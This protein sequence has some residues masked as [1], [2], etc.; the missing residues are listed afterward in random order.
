MDPDEIDVHEAT[1]RSESGGG[2]ANKATDPSSHPP[3]TKPVSEE[4]DRQNSANRGAADRNAADID[5]TS[6]REKSNL[7]GDSSRSSGADEATTDRGGPAS[8]ALPGIAEDKTV[9]SAPTSSSVPLQPTH[10]GT[11]AEITRVLLGHQLDHFYLETLIGGGGMGAVFRA[12][13]TR[14]DRTVAIKV[15]PRVGEDA[16]LQRRF[17][18]EAQS[19]ARLDHPNIARVYD[20][21]QHGGWH[22]IVFE[23]IEGIN[24]RDLVQRDGVLSVDDAVFYIRQIAEALDHAFRRGVVHRDIKPSNVLIT[25]GGQ[26]K[27][28]DMGLA[29]AQQLEMTDD[30]TAS[31]VTLG[32]F[33]YISPEQARD[34]RDTDV[35]SDIYSL[36]CTLYFA[37]TGR[38][39]YPSGTVLQ[40]LLS[41]GSSPPPDPRR[42]RRDLSASLVAVLHKML[43]KQ[44]ADRYRRPLDLISD[45]YQLA[46]RDHLV[47]ALSAGSIALAAPSRFVRTMEYHLPW[48]AAVLVLLVSAGWMQILSS[49]GRDL[50]LTAVPPRVVAETGPVENP[51]VQGGTDMASPPSLPTIAAP[52]PTNQSPSSGSS[53]E[54]GTGGNGPTGTG[55]NGDSIPQP[56]NRDATGDS[57]VGSDSSSAAPNASGNGAPIESSVGEDAAARPPQFPGV[58]NLAVLEGG[59]QRSGTAGATGP[60]NMAE[61]TQRSVTVVRVVGNDADAGGIDRGGRLLVTSLREAFEAARSNTGIAVIEIFDGTVRTGPLTLPRPGLI[62]RGVS[63]V[64]R[65]EFVSTDLSLSQ[66]PVMCELGSYGVELQN[67]QVTWAVPAMAVNG[68]SL[69]RCSGG[70]LVRLVDSTITVTNPSSAADV[71]AFEITGPIRIAPVGPA[72]VAVAPQ[73]AALQL[74]NCIVRGSMT[75]LGVKQSGRIELRWDNGLLAVQRSMVETTGAAGDSVGAVDSSGGSGGTPAT[76]LILDDVTAVLGSSLVSIRLRGE[77][78]KPLLVD[79]EANRCVFSYPSD[80]PLIRISG[81]TEGMSEDGL[82]VLRGRENR[83]DT[84]QGQLPIILETTTVDNLVNRFSFNE[85]LRASPPKWSSEV[86]PQGGVSWQ[87][88]PPA[89]SAYSQRGPLNYLQ[90]GVVSSGFRIGELPRASDTASVSDAGGI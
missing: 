27:L 23:Y 67:L 79:R 33:D 59:G 62:L 85:L 21:G 39:P 49:A 90:T 20:V 6:N 86:S 75:M 70:N 19:A 69:F 30:M 53:P 34:P 88:A 32:T 40:K 35:R 16:E 54:S 14:L 4:S 76:R 64:S 9:I 51:T 56:A 52:G 15:I 26:A 42:V 38:A 11:P 71:Y 60:A 31:G 58:P 36:G 22:Y 77:L 12:R 73:L 74:N 37:L 72:S 63:D 55:I 89:G 65:L 25:T 29:R 18:N 43:A 44:P 8:P 1:V 7:S 61:A 81:I 46:E 87:A 83:Y 82:V 17:R 48:I 5:A 57:A 50:E 78:T 80:S 66:R 84:P 10:G 28:V 3:A 13:D 45:L 2:A 47:R 68:G 41:H 24:L